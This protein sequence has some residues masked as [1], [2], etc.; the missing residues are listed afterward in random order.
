MLLG[1]G[2]TASR[3]ES[4]GGGFVSWTF[5]IDDAWIVQLPRFDAAAQTTRMQIRLM[6]EVQAVVP[7]AVPVPELIAE[8]ESRPVIGIPRCRVGLSSRQTNGF[9]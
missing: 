3:I 4:I 9:R 1:Q 8:W 7:F 6:P 2:I 5:D